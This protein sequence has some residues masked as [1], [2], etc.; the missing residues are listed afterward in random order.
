MYK[1]FSHSLNL[2][3]YKRHI[4]EKKSKNRIL[5]INFLNSDRGI[6]WPIKDFVKNF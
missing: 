3:Q 2:V 1:D 6:I 5:N 4:Q